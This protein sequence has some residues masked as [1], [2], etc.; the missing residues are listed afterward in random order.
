MILQYTYNVLLPYSCRQHRKKSYTTLLLLYCPSRLLHI[1]EIYWHCC[2]C[3]VSGRLF[4]CFF[5][6]IS[7]RIFFL[8]LDNERR[9]FLFIY[10][11]LKRIQ[12]FYSPCSGISTEKFNVSPWNHHYYWVS[13]FASHQNPLIHHSFVCVEWNGSQIFYRPRYHYVHPYSV[14][15]MKR[16]INLRNCMTFIFSYILM[17]AQ[18]LVAKKLDHY[19]MALS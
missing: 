4:C 12:H 2:L 6:F 8:A 17:F 1:Q 13:F 3:P 19:T 5:G 11:S 18:A 14:D 10:V 9:L 15:T 16:V 7:I